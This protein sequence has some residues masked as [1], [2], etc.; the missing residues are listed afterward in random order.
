MPRSQNERWEYPPARE[1]LD[2]S[3]LEFIGEYI[4]FHHSS[5]VQYTT[6]RSIFDILVA[7]GRRPGYPATIHWWD[8]E[9][10]RFVDEGR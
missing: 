8:Q 3:G 2:E 5:M 9:E 7:E 1:A 6:T 4:C 10:I